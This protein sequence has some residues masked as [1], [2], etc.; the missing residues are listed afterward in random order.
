MVMPFLI[1]VLWLGGGGDKVHC[2]LH[3]YVKMVNDPVHNCI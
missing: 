3:V 2:G 1:L